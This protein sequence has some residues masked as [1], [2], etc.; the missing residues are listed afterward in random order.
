M[1]APDVIDAPA[2]LQRRDGSSVYTQPDRHRWALKAT[3][4]Q[5]AWLLDVAGEPTGTTPTRDVIDAAVVF[6]DLGGDQADAVRELLGSQQRIGLLVGPAGAGKTR[7]LRAVVAA[8]QH[9]GGDVLG[10]TVSQ[11]AAGVLAEEA[12]VHA[13]NTAKWLHETRRGRWA[14]PH[15]ALVLID[16]RPWSPLQ[17]WSSSSSRP[18]ASAGRCC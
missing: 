14:L 13:E 5:E 16:E 6:H 3:L 8:R 10:L 18:A 9:D 7:T 12:H 1:T 2:E 17:T 4:D 11:A 15:G